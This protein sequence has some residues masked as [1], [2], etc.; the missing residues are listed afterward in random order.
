M[1]YRKSCNKDQYLFP[2]FQQ[3]NSCQRRNKQLV[4]QCILADDMF[5][6]KPK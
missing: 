1:P 3:I 5:P 2:V 4:I 6:A